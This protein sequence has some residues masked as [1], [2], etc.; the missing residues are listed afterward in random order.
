MSIR[1]SNQTRRPLKVLNQGIHTAPMHFDLSSVHLNPTQKP[2]TY[3]DVKVVQLL[4]I[5]FYAF[6]NN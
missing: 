1:L 6:R 3:S 2:V 5:V 4:V